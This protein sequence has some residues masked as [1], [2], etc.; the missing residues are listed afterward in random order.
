MEKQQQQQQLGRSVGV[1]GELR[2]YAADSRRGRARGSDCPDAR[3]ACG[4]KNGEQRR[5]PAA[6]GVGDADDARQSESLGV[7]TPRDW[8]VTTGLP[9]GAVSECCARRIRQAL[10]CVDWAAAGR[11]E[12]KC[13]SGMCE[14]VNRSTGGQ[15]CSTVVRRAAQGRVGWCMYG[16]CTEDV[17]RACTRGRDKAALA[18]SRGGDLGS[19]GGRLLG[20]R[21]GCDDWEHATVATINLA[22][23]SLR[24]SLKSAALVPHTEASQ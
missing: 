21:R 11:A 7:Q 22:R 17:L 12:C 1:A 6:V 10:V 16:V 19:G 14:V 15:Y 24:C 9:A 23:R 8:R 3:Q 20:A 13:D 4:T 5:A 2:L 18:C